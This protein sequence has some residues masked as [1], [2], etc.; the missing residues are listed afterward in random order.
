M[1]DAGSVVY[2]QAQTL[3]DPNNQNRFTEKQTFHILIRTP[4]H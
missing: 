1:I 3:A 2:G 4:P